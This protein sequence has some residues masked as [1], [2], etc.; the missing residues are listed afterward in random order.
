MSP[1]L[2]HLAVTLNDLSTVR[3]YRNQDILRREFDHLQDTQSACTFMS[4][5]TS[6]MFGLSLDI[7]CTLFVACVIFYFMF[8]DTGVSGEKIGL[9]VSQTIFMTGLASWGMKFAH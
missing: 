4:L 7:V 3:A 9:S 1:T 2:T 6:S 5:S 8:V